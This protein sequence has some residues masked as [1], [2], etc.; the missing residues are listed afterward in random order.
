[1]THSNCCGAT[2]IVETRSDHP[3]VYDDDYNLQIDVLICSQCGK[4][5]GLDS[6]N[7]N[8]GESTDI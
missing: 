1:M 8:L 4:I 2:T 7:G 6:K 5:V 3:H